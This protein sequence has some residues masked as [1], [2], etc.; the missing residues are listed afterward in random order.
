MSYLY[1]SIQWKQGGSQPETQESAGFCFNLLMNRPSAQRDDHLQ[2]LKTCRVLVPHATWITVKNTV[3]YFSK[4]AR[5][6]PYKWFLQYLHYCCE[7]FSIY[8]PGFLNA[9]QAAIVFDF[10]WYNLII[11]LQRLETCLDQPIH[12]SEHHVC[13]YCCQ[14]FAFVAWWCSCKCRLIWKVCIA[15]LHANNVTLTTLKACDG[16]TKSSKF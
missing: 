16:L 3:W 13:F 12:Q 15:L 1:G 5:Q 8:T 2:C 14:I 7:P 9:V 6:G 4:N 10:F 11:N